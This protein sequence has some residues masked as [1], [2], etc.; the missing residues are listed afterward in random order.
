MEILDIA[1]GAIAGAA[2]PGVAG[3]GAQ[4]IAAG[5]VAG[6]VAG[7]FYGSVG[8]G[9]MNERAACLDEALDYL[10]VTGRMSSHK[11]IETDEGPALFV[12]ATPVATQREVESAVLRCRP[13][14]LRW[15]A[16]TILRFD[17]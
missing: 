7:W 17:F 9:P 12:Y 13:A 6:A 14:S 16:P 1:L 15:V 2:F 11:T 8:D 10:A 4:E 5:G 3:R